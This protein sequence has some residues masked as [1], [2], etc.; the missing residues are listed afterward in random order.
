[1]TRI[2]AKCPSC[3]DVEFGIESIVVLLGSE[4]LATS[5]RL[6]V[7]VDD[8]S[9][10]ADR[11]YRFSCP[12]CT[13][14]VRRSAVPDVI[15]LLITAGVRVEAVKGQRRGTAK[16]AASTTPVN[17]GPRLTD[18]DVDAFRDLLSEPDWFDK[19]KALD[20]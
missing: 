8:V 10:A 4:L 19:L 6:E 5:D 11:S 14:H 17:G 2:R 12:M 20:R 1:M 16:P 13:T 9:V 3:G 15:E 7:S 18:A